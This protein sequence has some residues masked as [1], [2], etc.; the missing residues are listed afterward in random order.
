MK[1]VLLGA[2]LAINTG[3]NEGT[4]IQPSDL[5]IKRSPYR[6][7]RLVVAKGE[8]DKVGEMGSLGIVDANIAFRMAEQ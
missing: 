5:V 7:N 6:E 8:G 2:D 1:A 3:A 4:E